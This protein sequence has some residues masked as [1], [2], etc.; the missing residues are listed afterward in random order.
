M[1]GLVLKVGDYGVSKV[2]GST[3]T[4]NTTRF[5]SLPYTAPEII[6]DKP[7]SKPA[8]VFGLGSIFY[9]LLTLEKAYPAK[10]PER[11]LHIID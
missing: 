8:D 2:E 1:E 3:M 6:R 9:E 5:F 10:T 7:Y 11:F 4:N